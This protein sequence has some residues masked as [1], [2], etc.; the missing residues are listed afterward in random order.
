MT[1]KNMMI[2]GLAGIILI[3]AT[4]GASAYVATRMADDKPAE[5]AKTASVTHKAK[6]DKITWNEPRQQAQPQ[7]VQPEKPACNDSNIIGTALGAVGGGLVGNQ[8]G[9]GKGK[10]LA[11]IGGAVAGGFAGHEYI[12]TH[13]TLCP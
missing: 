8:I 12:P 1:R 4:A 10:D 13:N 3:A 6:G 11:T 5:T 7:A 2:A 9:G